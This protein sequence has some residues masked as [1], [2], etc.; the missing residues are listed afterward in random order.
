MEN[1]KC[2]CGSKNIERQYDQYNI[3][4]GKMCDKCFNKKYN[5]NDFDAAYCGESLEENY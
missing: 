3:Y 5:H 4:C 2:E 1:E